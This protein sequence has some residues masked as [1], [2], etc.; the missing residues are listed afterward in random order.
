MF[1][2]LRRF[3]GSSDPSQNGTSPN[4]QTDERLSALTAELAQARA[5]LAQAQAQAGQRADEHA[6]ALSQLNGEFKILTDSMPQFVWMCSPDGANI[7]C[8]QRW[9]DY[10]GLTSAQST[11][12]A[13]VKAFHPDD[14]RRVQEAWEKARVLGAPYNLECRIQRPDGQ[15]RWFIVTGLPL[16]NANGAT[17]KWLG[18]CTDIHSQKEAEETLRRQQI[19]LRVLFD[20]MPAFIWFK[21]TQNKILRVNR[22]AADAAGK[23]VDEIEGRPSSEIYPKDAERFYADDLQVIASKTPK[24]GYVEALRTGEGEERWVQTDKVPYFNKEGEVIGIVV[25]ARDVTAERKA[26]EENKSQEARFTSV[27]EGSRDAI[28]LMSDKG[29]FDCNARALELFGYT[30]KSQLIGLHPAT[31][32]PPLQPDGQESF[33]KGNDYVMRAFKEGSYRFEWTHMRKNGEEF[34]AEVHLSAYEYDGRMV[35]Q[36]TSHDISERKRAQEAL[37]EASRAAGMAEVATNVLHNVG[38]VLNSVNIS[39]AVLTDHVSDAGASRLSKVVAVLKEHQHDIGEFVTSDPQGKQLTAY[40]S[41]LAEH[42]AA[43]QVTVL[44]ELKSLQRNVEHIKTIVAMQQNYAKVTGNAEVVRVDDLINDSIQIIGGALNRHKIQVVQQFEPVG[45]V[46]AE[47]HKI[48]QVLVNLIRNAEQACAE[49][50]RPDK[51]ILLRITSAAGRIQVIVSDNG[52]G[53]PAENLLRIF[54]QGFTTKVDGHG[55]GLHS[56]ALTAKE[57]GGSLTAE[58][59]GPGQGATFTLDFPMKP[60]AEI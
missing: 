1:G 16:L 19:E 59:T 49:S 46:K 53:I 18:T 27:F 45:P 37:R 52:V 47:K 17:T 58:S 11:G 32:S 36:G 42:E 10:T 40:L 3:L 2:L 13:W 33:A 56:A 24:L 12:D 29:I 48:L 31:L 51:K 38:N 9:T 23:S 41:Q 28:I 8:N 57:M 25:M 7:Y 60:A 39:A 44:E 50:S 26:N 54:N 30:S 5:L 4:P 55:F 35:I 21:D 20:L 15:Y 6:K 14:R 34:Q 22:V 43:R